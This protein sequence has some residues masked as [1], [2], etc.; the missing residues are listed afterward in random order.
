MDALERPASDVILDAILNNETEWATTFRGKIPWDELLNSSFPASAIISTIVNE[1]A[2]KGV[3][4]ALLALIDSALLDGRDDILKP[5]E[6]EGYVTHVPCLALI[7]HGYERVLLRFLDAGFHPEHR[8]GC[9]MSAIAAADIF[10]CQK[11]AGLMRSHVARR[12]INAALEPS[13]SSALSR[14]A[15]G[16]VSP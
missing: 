8:G 3:E 10:G 14:H 4:D 11:V 6:V 12:M 1:G 2:R 15:P 16:G 5:F 7:T 9:E 13:E